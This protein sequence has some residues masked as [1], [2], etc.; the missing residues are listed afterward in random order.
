MNTSYNAMGSKIQAGY[1]CKPTQ[2]DPTKP[3]MHYRSHILMCDGDRCKATY[4]EPIIDTLRAQLKAMNLSSGDNRIKITRTGCFGA[5][6]FRAVGVL[7]EYGT[8]TLIN[9]GIWLKNLH[10]YNQSHWEDLF[11]CLRHGISLE[12]RYPQQCIPMKVF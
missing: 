9:N 10:Q 5:C 8:N 4:K 12:E 11:T 6:R 3:I 2:V 1:T 7:Y